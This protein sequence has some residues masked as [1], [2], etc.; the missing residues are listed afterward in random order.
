MPHPSGQRGANRSM[1]G[2]GTVHLVDGRA[3][4]GDVN[5]DANTVTVRGRLRVCSGPDSAPQVTYR[6]LVM[7]TWPVALVREIVWQIEEAA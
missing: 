7:K 3:Y 2:L 6:R 4:R 5:L 1:H